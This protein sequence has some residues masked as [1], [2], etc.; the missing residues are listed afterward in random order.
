MRR[1][2]EASNTVVSMCANAVIQMNVRW[3]ST[4][5]GL[6]SGSHSVYIPKDQTSENK[7]AYD[8]HTMNPSGPLEAILRIQSVRYADLISQTPSSPTTHNM[9][10]HIQCWIAGPTPNR[11]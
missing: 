10:C 11:A 2:D 3:L 6:A 4:K 7:V 8:A 5:C 1:D 9:A